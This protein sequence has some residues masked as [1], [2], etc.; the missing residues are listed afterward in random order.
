MRTDLY[1]KSVR[2]RR[3]SV[4][5]AL[6]VDVELTVGALPAAVDAHAVAVQSAERRVACARAGGHYAVAACVVER[7]VAVVVYAARVAPDAEVDVDA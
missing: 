7:H 3:D 5:G 2:S 4:V 1:T 6:A